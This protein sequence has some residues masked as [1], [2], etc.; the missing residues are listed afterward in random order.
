MSQGLRFSPPGQPLPPPPDGAAFVETAVSLDLV[1][2]LVTRLGTVRLQQELGE[3]VAGRLL[4]HIL[5]G[6][7]D[8][9]LWRIARRH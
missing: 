3:S 1:P 9:L 4:R 5:A 2:R 8:H 6:T 7:F